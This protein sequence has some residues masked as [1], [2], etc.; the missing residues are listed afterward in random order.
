[1]SLSVGI[2]G[3]P[4]AGKSTLFNALLGRQV[5]KAENYPFC[6]IE[7]NIGVVEVPDERLP[8]LAKIEKSQAII[9]AVVKFVDIAGL[10]KGAA[11][12]EGLGNKFLAHIR[13][14]DL[15][16]YLLRFFTD[17]NIDRAG[18]INP[19]DDLSVLRTELS[20]KDLETLEKSLTKKPKND[21]EILRFQIVNKISSLLERGIL[22][23]SYKFGK[24]EKEVLDNLFLLTAKEEMIVL[25]VGEKDLVA[26]S[27]IFDK[28]TNLDPVVVCAKTEEEL[29]LLNLEERKE[30]LA[31]LG[32]RQS[33]LEKLIKQ[34]YQKLGLISF[35]TAGEKEA[36]A[37]TVKDGTLAP[38]AAG[39]IH[40]DF[41][42]SFIKAEVANFDDFVK[43]GG[44]AKCRTLGKTRFEGQD[45][46][47]SN[48]EVVEFRVGKN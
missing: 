33:G 20:L 27:E 43:F 37:W 24:E 34:A 10:V 32:V 7:P 41:E 29:S 48:D 46:Q 23:N 36:R 45:Y 3:L 5:A 13:E 31:G 22:P 21:E 16:C 40:S 15:I 26:G 12:G 1:M 25:N 8:V 42:K 6:T 35:Y 19:E 14:V 39:V 47:I 44:W 28:F 11:Q 38:Q 18:S 9:P 4:N 30:Y 2:V 17:D